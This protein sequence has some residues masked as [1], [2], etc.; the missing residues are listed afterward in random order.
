MLSNLKLLTPHDFAEF[1]CSDVG[2]VKPIEGDG[3][4]TYAA[5]AADG[6][7]LWQFDDRNAALA[8]LRRHELLPVSVH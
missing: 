6:S 3:L 2:Y 7:F 4:V 8:M 5:H 1:G